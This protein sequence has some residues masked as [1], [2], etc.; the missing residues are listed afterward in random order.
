MVDK[1]LT[2]SELIRFRRSTALSELA[3]ATF[4]SRTLRGTA[5]H[6]KRTESGSPVAPLIAWPAPSIVPDDLEMHDFVNRK[7]AEQFEALADPATTAAATPPV[8]SP[9]RRFRDSPDPGSVAKPWKKPW[10]I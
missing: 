10:D 8:E 6:R 3:L 1:K 7:L 2:N 4:R 5:A 9:E